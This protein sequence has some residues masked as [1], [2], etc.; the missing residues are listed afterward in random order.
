MDAYIMLIYIYQTSQR[1]T[2]PQPYL[3]PVSKNQWGALA[4]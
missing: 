3:D 1:G 2:R 4:R